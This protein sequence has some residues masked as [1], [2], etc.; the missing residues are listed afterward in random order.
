MVEDAATRY[1]R[2]GWWTGER[3]V[4]RFE[5]HVAQGPDEL[6]LISGDTLSRTELWSRVGEAAEPGREP[7]GNGA[8][9]SGRTAFIDCLRCR[10]SRC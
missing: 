8:D 9:H 4:D 10:R 7:A 5:S 1:C 6:A 2:A 3:L